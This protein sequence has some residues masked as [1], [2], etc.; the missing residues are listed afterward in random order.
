MNNPF[1]HG[2]SHCT[3]NGHTQQA[4]NTDEC[5]PPTASG[6]HIL[7]PST[8]TGHHEPDGYDVFGR[9]LPRCSGSGNTTTNCTHPTT[10][11]PAPSIIP[12][13]TRGTTI[14]PSNLKGVDTRRDVV[15]DAVLAGADAHTVEV[16]HRCPYHM[17]EVYS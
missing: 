6:E 2:E 11:L 10:N 9:C 4:C 14:H 16:V 8:A 15:V 12:T 7:T 5:V 1:A 17:S 13:S 3:N